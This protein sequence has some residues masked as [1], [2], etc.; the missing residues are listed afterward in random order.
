MDSHSPSPLSTYT[1]IQNNDKNPNDQPKKIK[2]NDLDTSSYSLYG[3][4]YILLTNTLLYP[5]ELLRTRLQADKVYY[6]LI[7][8]IKR[9]FYSRDLY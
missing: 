8:L 7:D 5:S 1:A 6:L 4:A 3:A 9:G 2:W